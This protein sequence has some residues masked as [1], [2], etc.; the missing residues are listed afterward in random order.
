MGNR[1]KPYKLV[2]HTSPTRPVP[3]TA[4]DPV[5]WWF[6]EKPKKIY[7]AASLNNAEGALRLAF[8]LQKL[9]LKVT[10]R[11]LGHDFSNSCREVD[12][13]PYMEQEKEWARTDLEDMDAADTLVILS[14]MASSSG[15]FHVELGYFIGR[16][17]ENILVVGNRPNVFY[18]SDNVRYASTSH[19]VAEWLAS[20]KHGPKYTDF[21]APEL[22]FAA[23]EP[24]SFQ[25]DQEDVGEGT[26]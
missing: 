13:R 19:G 26:F 23:P 10:S 2:D 11:W 24:V 16:K 15:G 22:A 20:D 5:L 18:W 8:D 7:V 3:A 1:Y 12:W 17:I 25:V 9:G 14:N 6:P 4:T 21:A